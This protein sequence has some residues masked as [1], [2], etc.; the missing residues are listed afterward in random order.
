MRISELSTRTGVPVA[1]IKYYLREGVLPAGERT[2]ATQAVYGE[3]HVERLALV[4]ALVEVAG[5]SVAGVKELTAVL[6]AGQPLGEVFGVAQRLVSAGGQPATEESS[7]RVVQLTSGD[8]QP[9]SDVGAAMAARAL[10]GFAAGDRVPSETWLR[11][12]WE[13]AQLV[14]RA[15]LEEVGRRPGTTERVRLVA[16]GTSMGDVLLAGLRRVAQAQ[17]TRTQLTRTQPE[18][19]S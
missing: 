8:S 7:A 10:D 6:D 15:D 18:E 3:H 14:A 2:S 4:R 12:Y 19:E 9:V 11:T 5:V 13:A 17:L 1:T 16:V